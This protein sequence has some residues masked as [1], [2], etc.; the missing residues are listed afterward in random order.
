[1]S[2]KG[3]AL[4]MRLIVLGVAFLSVTVILLIGWQLIGPFATAFDGTNNPAGWPTPSGVLP[5][6]G[7]A[8][9]ALPVV[10]FVWW[11]AAPVRADKRQQYR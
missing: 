10:L 7:V 4:I 5:F 3:I 1:M 9:L 2:G 11:W 6:V 8:S